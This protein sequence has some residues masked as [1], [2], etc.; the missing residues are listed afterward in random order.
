M[1]GGFFSKFDSESESEESESS[2][3]VTQTKARRAWMDE[4][5]DESEEEK[6]VV[7]STKDRRW[8]A[9]KV[10]CK[11][12]KNHLRIADFVSVL[13]D[14]DEMNKQL[15]KARN[16]IESEGVPTFYVRS[17]VRLEDAVNNT[18]KDAI[19]KMS[20]HNNKSFTKLKLQLKKHNREYEENIKAFR[21][22]PV[23]SEPSEEEAEESEE[24]EEEQP[25]KTKSTKK[26][27]EESEEE[28][29]DEEEWGSGDEEESEES[30]ESDYE[31]P[32]DPENR[33]RF[34]EI[35]EKKGEKVKTEEKAKPKPV[36]TKKKEE[37]V[38]AEEKVE[39]TP[40]LIEAKFLNL[41]E[42]WSKRVVT[43]KEQVDAL[44]ELLEISKDN[45]L[46]AAVLLM[47]VPAEFA[48]SKNTVTQVMP[49]DLW[50]SAVAH[51]K[52]LLELNETNSD[53]FTSNDEEGRSNIKKGLAHY[54]ER[55]NEELKKS[56]KTFEPQTNKYMER[57]KDLLILNN[58]ENRVL[59]FFTKYSGDSASI[60]RIYLLK[61]EH[62]HYLHDDLRMQMKQLYQGTDSGLYF[63][64][65]NSK[66]EV[67]KLA[68]YC[69]EHG[70]AKTKAHAALMQVFHLALHGH[71]TEARRLLNL[72]NLNE[73][74][75]SDPHTQILYNRAISNVGISAFCHG[76]IKEAFELLNDIVSSQRIRELLGQIVAPNK[77]KTTAQER[78]EKKRL[79]PYH[80]H[81]QADLLEAAYYISA[82]LID[83]PKMAQNP[84]E[85]YKNTQSRILKKLKEF[86]EK[87]AII[88]PPETNRDSI[89]AAAKALQQGHWKDARESIEKMEIWRFVPKTD[90]V[91]ELVYKKLKESALATY[92]LSYTEVYE[93]FN[94]GQLAYMFELSEEEVYTQISK[95]IL[96]DELQA[97]WDG[98]IL[99]MHKN[100]P[101]K[102]QFLATQ[103]ADK[104]LQTLDS[105]EKLLEFKGALTRLISEQPGAGTKKAK[106]QVRK[107]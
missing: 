29:S 81:L 34:W 80:M 53:I 63:Q 41:K 27:V 11:A 58:L 105:N 12:L 22:N 97:S 89:I 101:N 31:R 65:E 38:R 15:L 68:N 4:S 62:I 55:L 5:S 42:D 30:E 106:K 102:L 2:E 14:F 69:Y 35:K 99:I 9:I 98:D 37:E 60:S 82:M 94:K 87:Q 64:V 32:S 78:E 88:G 74:V 10:H 67:S 17:L 71:Y 100:I 48:I 79:L 92:I 76:N 57:L 95:L 40:A 104:A 47:L 46:K 16:I 33:R 72:T 56:L 54:I 73:S 90:Q 86:Y 23:E 75:L 39:M 77:E 24:S 20:T 36:R 7:R 18:S 93:S 49:R 107:V 21:A 84:Y 96:S 66:D 83:T 6:R 43:P 59:A 19:K 1:K 44:K 85:P 3:E 28:E 61:I 103:F 25:K 51:L 8:D 91:K 50:L 13:N 70:D 52:S 26:K 45:R